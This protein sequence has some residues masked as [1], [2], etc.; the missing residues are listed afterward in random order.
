MKLDQTS[1]VDCKPGSG[2]KLVLRI[3][4]NVDLVDGADNKSKMH[5]I[6]AAVL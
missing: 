4:Q 3:A 5:R 2:K 1:T 6:E